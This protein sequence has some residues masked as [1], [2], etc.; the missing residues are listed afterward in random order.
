MSEFIIRRYS[1]VGILLQETPAFHNVTAVKSENTIGNIS[2]TYPLQGESFDS[3][4]RN[5]IIEVEENWQGSKSYLNNT[6][7]FLRNYAFRSS[8]GKKIVH[9]FAYDALWLLTT[10]IVAYYAGS[11]QASKYGAADDMLKE[12]IHE[13]LGYLAG[14]DRRIPDLLVDA[15]L[16]QNATLQDGFSRKMVYDVC[17]DI[18]KSSHEMNSP[19]YFDIERRATTELIFKT[20][21]GQRGENHG[22]FSGDIRTVSEEEGTLE[23]Y[24]LAYRSSDE[25]NYI[26]V[27]GGGEGENRY[28]YERDNE[29]RIAEGYPY[30]R[31][32]K[33]I[34]GRNMT[35]F[36]EMIRA[37][38]Q[39]LEE[40]KPKK[41]LTG[42]LIP[43][44]AMQYN[45]DF[46]FGDIVNAKA[47]GHS[48]DVHISTVTTTIDEDNKQTHDIRLRGET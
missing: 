32:E 6:V 46:G 39:A 43:T 36:A 4:K 17:R 37:S 40:G 34:D 9:L 41:V 45:T 19:L 5:Q 28:V 38:F 33:F 44:P 10:R 11:D 48:V 29:D 7:Y 15:D 26:Y 20:Y 16:T 8:K 42:T 35:Y 27:G 31:I 2:L 14:E 24:E 21:K 25:A 1:P 23:D 3:Y 30:N 22:E 13:N 12:V 18:A 47:F